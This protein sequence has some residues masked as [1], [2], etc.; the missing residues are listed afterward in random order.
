MYHSTVIVLRVISL[1]GLQGNGTLLNDSP[2]QLALAQMY[3]VQFIA[4]E[5]ANQT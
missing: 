3:N 4:F 5:S 2:N 1:F